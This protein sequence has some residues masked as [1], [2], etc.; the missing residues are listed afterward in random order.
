LLFEKLNLQT[1]IHATA[2]LAFFGSPNDIAAD[3]ASITGVPG[4]EKLDAPRVVA[5][6][7]MTYFVTEAGLKA[8]NDALA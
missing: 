6:D 2:S 4:F 5:C 8:L 1:V 3:V 7:H